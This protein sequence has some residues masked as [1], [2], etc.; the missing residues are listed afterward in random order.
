[1]T[2][3][4]STPARVVVLLITVGVVLVLL[5]ATGVAAGV[6]TPAPD[7]EVAFATYRVAAGDTLWDIAA[8][9]TS[10]EDDVRRTVYEIRVLN[11]LEGTLIVPG[12]I[13]RIPGS[14]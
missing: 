6:G 11:E 1:M 8:H 10:P 14:G 12:Q 9:H 2:I 4:A 7:G 13:L 5:L 3:S